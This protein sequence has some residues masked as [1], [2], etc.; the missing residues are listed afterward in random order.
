MQAQLLRGANVPLIRSGRPVPWDMAWSTE[1]FPIWTRHQVSS[2]GRSSRR[3]IWLTSPPLITARGLG[4]SL[5]PHRS[6]PALASVLRSPS[7][8]QR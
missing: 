1:H 4:E 6:T 3:G 2:R 5:F 7:Q 8:V